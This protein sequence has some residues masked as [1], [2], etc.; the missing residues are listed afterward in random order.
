MSRYDHDLDV[1]MEQHFFPDQASDLA[2]EEPLSTEDLEAMM[3]FHFGHLE[4]GCDPFAGR[5]GETP[6]TAR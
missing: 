6:S 2:P 1:Q 4:D 3:E 5:D